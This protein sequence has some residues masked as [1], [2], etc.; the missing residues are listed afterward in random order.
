MIIAPLRPGSS[1]GY[2]VNRLARLFEA[3]L[4][5]RIVAHG[6]VP[7]QFPALLALFEHDGQ[8]QRE[9]CD[10]ASVDQSTMAKTLAR[11]RRDGLV[12]ATPDPSDGRCTRYYLTPAARAL[13]PELAAAGHAVIAQAT[14][15]IPAAR[16][17]ALDETLAD[18]A[19]NLTVSRPA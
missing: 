7:G 14:Q 13:E 19:A 2:Q 16:L 6:V 18:M 17:A 11:M 1:V 3:A 9:L 10:V 15:G 4:R 8:T 5:A 12:D